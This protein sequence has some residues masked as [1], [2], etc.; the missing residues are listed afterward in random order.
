MT[1]CSGHIRSGRSMSL[2]SRLVFDLPLQPVVAAAFRNFSGVDYVRFAIRG[3][4]RSGAH[5]EMTMVA[6]EN[7]NRSCWTRSA[8]DRDNRFFAYRRFRR[9]NYARA[10]APANAGN[11]LQS[12]VAVHASSFTTPWSRSSQHSPDDV[13]GRALDLEIRPTYS[14]MI[15]K[16]KRMCPTKT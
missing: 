1:L 16:N 7:S 13:L 5:T 6:L 2:A 14:P 9:L 10:S 3:R 12:R 4:H 8:G 15:P 11:S